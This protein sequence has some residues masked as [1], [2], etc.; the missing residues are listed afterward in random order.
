[1]KLL[2]DKAEGGPY[3]SVVTQSGVA[4]LGGQ[5]DLAFYL[6]YVTIHE[7]MLVS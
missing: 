5:G 2:A 1:M 4:N 7:L 3:V 6:L